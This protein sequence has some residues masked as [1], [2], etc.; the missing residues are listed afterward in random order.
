[1]QNLEGKAFSDEE[2]PYQSPGRM[3][4]SS[5][6]IA[7]V[8]VRIHDLPHTVASNMGSPITPFYALHLIAPL[9]FHPHLRS[10]LLNIVIFISVMDVPA[11]SFQQTH[12]GR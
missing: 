2:K 6:Y 1:M 4:N 11:V 3:K 9:W 12:V 5:Y 10:M 7:P 8:G